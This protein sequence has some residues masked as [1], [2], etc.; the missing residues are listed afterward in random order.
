MSA[1]NEEV[2]AGFAITKRNSALDL[3]Y[4]HLGNARSDACEMKFFQ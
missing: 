1:A 4:Q 2:I 3:P